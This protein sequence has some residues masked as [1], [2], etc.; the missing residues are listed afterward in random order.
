L[1]REKGLTLEGLSSVCGLSAGFISQVERGLS[2]LSIVSLRAISEALGVSPS[3]LFLKEEEPQVAES[4]GISPVKKA[5]DQLRIQIGEYPIT[6]RYLSGEFSNR[7]MEVLINEF[8]PN[9]SHPLAPHRGEEF[10]YVLE[11][12]LILKIGKEE[13]FLAP[14]DSY[15]FLASR[16]HSYRTSEKQGAKVLITTTQKLLAWHGGRREGFRPIEPA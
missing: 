8:P 13:Y 9:Y 15:H 6:Y 3:E 5:V 7:I 10:G 14:G 11:G 12:R 2:S 1:R 4:E 16:P